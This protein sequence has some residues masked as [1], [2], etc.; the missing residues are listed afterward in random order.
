VTTAALPSPKLQ[1]HFA[2]VEPGEAVDW[3]V[4][5]KSSSSQVGLGREN[6]ATGGV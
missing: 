6:F 3:S 5:V 4:K 1:V 2:I